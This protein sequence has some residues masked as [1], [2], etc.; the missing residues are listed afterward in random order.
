MGEKSTNECPTGRRQNEETAERFLS[1]H[2]LAQVNNDFI[3]ESDEGKNGWLIR[4]VEERLLCVWKGCA[5][6][7]WVKTCPVVSLFIWLQLARVEWKRREKADKKERTAVSYGCMREIGSRKRTCG[8]SDGYSTCGNEHTCPDSKRGEGRT[9]KRTEKTK[10]IVEIEFEVHQNGRLP[11][12][13]G[14]IWLEISQTPENNR[15]DRLFDQSIDDQS[16]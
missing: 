14:N 11:N 13:S 16:W 1:N 15:G 10:K 3:D 5:C 4:K 7:S 12:E 2:H 8:D 6:V 9:K